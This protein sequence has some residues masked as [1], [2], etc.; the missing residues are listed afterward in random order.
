MEGWPSLKNMRTT[1][2]ASL[3]LALLLC[4]CASGVEGQA[5][6]PSSKVVAP[7]AT[8]TASGTVLL[9][10]EKI[11]GF[12]IEGFQLD[13]RLEA[14][15][16]HPVISS[17]WDDLVHELHPKPTKSEFYGSVIRTTVPAGSFVFTTV[18]HPGMGAKQPPC[19]TGGQVKPGA[20]ATVTVRFTNAGECSTVSAGEK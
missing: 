3:V 17:T 15:S 8:A 2:S 5:F 19:I 20:V 13:V 16:G 12:L 6:E 1:Q 7:S 4:G 9:R 10:L 18:M 11:D 14:P